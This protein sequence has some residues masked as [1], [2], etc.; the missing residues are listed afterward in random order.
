MQAI[1]HMYPSYNTK[2]KPISGIG[3]KELLYLVP[4]KE[5]LVLPIY[6]FNVNSSV[7]IHELRAFRTKKTLRSYL[8]WTLA[9][10]PAGLQQMVNA[11]LLIL[12]EQRLRTLWSAS[13]TQPSV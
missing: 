7:F 9:L 2:G 6:L 1:T 12:K 11:Y 13:I 4:K 8:C 3:I 5:L 10:V